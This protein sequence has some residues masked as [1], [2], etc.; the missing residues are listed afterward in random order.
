MAYICMYV[1][2]YVCTY[3]KWKYRQQVH[4]VHWDTDKLDNVLPRD[5]AQEEVYTE[6]GEVFK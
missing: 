2:M 4:D 5:H 6:T 1:C 3:E